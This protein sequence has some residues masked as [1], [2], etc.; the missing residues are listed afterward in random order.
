MVS[1]RH[2]ATSVPPAPVRPGRDQAAAETERPLPRRG[3][4]PALLPRALAR[5]AGVAWGPDGPPAAVGLLLVVPAGDRPQGDGYVTR[6]ACPF[7]AG[8]RERLVR[9]RRY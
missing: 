2:S 8:S 4:I 7:P 5:P 1:P 3:R 9:P 6:V